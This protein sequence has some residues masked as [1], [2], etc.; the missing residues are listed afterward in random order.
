MTKKVKI[1][2]IIIPI[3]AAACI[4]GGFYYHHVQVVKAEEL[5]IAQEKKDAK[6]DALE[7]TYTAT[8]TEITNGIFSDDDRTN[9]T[10]TLVSYQKG[11]KKET[12]TA[13]KI[14]AF[15]A[16]V[17]DTDKKYT[18]GKAT[19]DSAMAGIQTAYPTDMTYYSD[20]FKA[21]L[22]TM[23]NDYNTLVAAGKY[24]DAYN[25]YNEINTLYSNYVA[26]KQ[27][28]E[29]AAAKARADAEAKAKADAEA[30]AKAASASKSTSSSTNVSKSSSTG[31]KSGS[32]GKTTGGTSGQSTNGIR[33]GFDP[34][35]NLPTDATEA[36]MQ[37]WA[38]AHGGKF[39]NNGLQGAIDD[40]SNNRY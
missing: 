13:K 32:T 40:F 20:D 30:K 3:V 23:T 24:Q 2:A 7:K 9:L 18:D 33:A 19:L 14:T 21:S 39:G 37:A 17:K 10:K 16:F 5:K 8:E 28:E 29:A 36:E 35:G 11:I 4:G 1:A 12:L 22:A 31:K 26:Q 27:A 34:N 25:K 38:A 15:K 6:F